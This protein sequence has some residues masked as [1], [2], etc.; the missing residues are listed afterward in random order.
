MLENKIPKED[1]TGKSKGDLKRERREKQEKQ[2]AAKIEQ[3][4]NVTQKNQIKNS[5]EPKDLV[6]REI[7][8]NEKAVH[9]IDQ[10]NLKHKFQD[11]KDSNK[12]SGEDVVTPLSNQTQDKQSPSLSRSIRS[13]PSFS[14]YE[15]DHQSFAHIPKRETDL[16]ELTKDLG[17]N[18][19]IIHSDIIKIGLRMNQNLICDP[20]TRCIS[21]LVALKNAFRDYEPDSESTKISADLNKKMEEYTTFL[22]RCRPLS[23]SMINVIRIIK[24]K[25]SDLSLD[26]NLKEAKSHLIDSIDKFMYEEVECGLNGIRE[27]G[28]LKINDNDVILT[29][30]DSFLTKHIFK[31]AKKNGKKFR[32]VVVDS[33]PRL[34][35]KKFLEFLNQLNIEATYVL[36]SAISYVMKEVNK[37]LLEAHTLLANGY[38]ISDM[39]SSQI[40]LVAKSHN[41]PVLVCCETYKFSERVHTDSF[42]FNEAGKWIKILLKNGNK[43]Y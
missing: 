23:V 31:E 39:G 13:S 21:F 26:I 14:S 20:T 17:F 3:N 5:S 33:H 4:S 30:G 7:S 2:R 43:F 11:F 27:H 35:G 41:V 16:I 19:K 12:N 18:G 42:V 32:V 1:K 8:L 25:I 10:H 40:A 9:L 38:M 24:S 36:I 34:D 22:D 28:N 15:R 29:F 37:V 6:D